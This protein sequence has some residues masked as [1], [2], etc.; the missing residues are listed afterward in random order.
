M[1]RAKRKDNYPSFPFTANIWTAVLLMLLFCLGFLISLRWNAMG[2]ATY[3]VLW[4]LS[5]VI[6]YAGTCRNCVYYGKRCPI[7][8]EGSC[9]HRFF[10]RGRN[11]FG[12]LSIV[13]AALAYAFRILV[14]LFI[15]INDR[16][17]IGG[18][19]YFGLLALFWAN[20]LGFAGCPNCINTDCPL[21]PDYTRR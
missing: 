5:Y 4:G 20:H 11:R 13:W 10:E 16:W 15:I 18:I 8:L 3:M 19:A 14:P 9:V 17:L 12:Y 21:N 1:L 2:A 7:P 6:I